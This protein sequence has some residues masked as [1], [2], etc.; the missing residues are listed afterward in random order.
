MSFVESIPDVE[1]EAEYTCTFDNCEDALYNTYKYSDGQLKVRSAYSEMGEGG[2][3]PECDEELDI[4]LIELDPERYEDG[5]VCPH[6]GEE[7]EYEVDVDEYQLELV[8]GQ[9]NDPDG[10]RSRLQV[11]FEDDIIIM[12]DDGIPEDKTEAEDEPEI[13]DVFIAEPPVSIEIIRTQLASA[14]SGDTVTMGQWFVCPNLG[15]KNM[16]KNYVK[17]YG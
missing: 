10:F 1:L 8:D 12:D 16:I 5:Y 11:N 14:K 9:W 17:L 13:E 6:C 4:R 2:Y 7:I 3:C 15:L